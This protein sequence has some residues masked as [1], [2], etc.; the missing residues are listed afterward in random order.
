MAAIMG[1]SRIRG[2]M[3]KD[4]NHAAIENNLIAGKLN[5]KQPGKCPKS[6]AQREAF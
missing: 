2:R 6:G 5:S 1:S 4:P 3:E